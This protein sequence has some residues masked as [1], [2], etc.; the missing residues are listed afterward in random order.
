M[1]RFFLDSSIV[2]CAD[3]LDAPAK[4]SAALGPLERAYGDAAGVL[5]LQVLQEYYVTATRK[6]GVPTADARRKVELLSRP[7]VV[8][9][10][11]TDILAAID[12]QGLHGC[13]FWDALIVQAALPARC[14]VLYTEDLQPGMRIGGLQIVNP[15]EGVKGERDEGLM[16]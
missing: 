4:Q 8:R 2:A 5:S 10:D 7:A 11:P 3:D 6:L 12:M 14:T 15:F 16:A 9:L 13:S 1:A